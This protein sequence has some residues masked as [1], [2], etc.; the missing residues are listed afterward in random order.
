MCVH[1]Y[2]LS[3]GRFVQLTTVIIIIMHDW[4]PF[5]RL[6]YVIII[7]LVFTI[8]RDRIPQTLTKILTIPASVYTTFLLFNLHLVAGL[9]ATT[10]FL[11]KQYTFY[12]CKSVL[13]MPSVT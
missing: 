8:P 3:L 7:T 11:E 6:F 9:E 1:V 2:I 5:S 10:T 4:R 12:N 13:I